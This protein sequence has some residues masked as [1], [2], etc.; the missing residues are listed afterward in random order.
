MI[1]ISKTKFIGLSVLFLQFIICSIIQLFGIQL[2]YER[3]SILAL[4]QTLL[5]IAVL[6]VSGLPIV[7]VPNM[8]G[9]FSLLFH[10]A[11]II[12]KGFNIKGTVPLPFENYAEISTIQIAFS[13]YLI[14]QT[15]YYI[16]L[17]VGF[18]SHEESIIA[19]KYKN[20]EE[21]ADTLV[22]GKVLLILGTIPR[23]YIDIVS[24]IGARNSGYAG[25]Y[26]LYIPG[27][28][29]AMAFFFDA[30]L[31]FVLFGCKKRSDV[32]FFAVLVYKC[33]M[34]TTGSRQDKVVFLLIW[35]YIFFF[36]INQ[37]TF[38]KILALVGACVVGFV[39]IS[40]VGAA[41][42][43]DSTGIRET[44]NVMQDGK[45]SNMLGGSLGE[46]GASFVTLE[47]AI[48][49]TPSQ[50][51]YGYGRSYLA[52]VLS[53]IPL[54]VKQIPVLAKTGYFLSQLPDDLTFAFG[55][56]YLGELYYNF[57]WVGI[58]GSYVVGS[59]NITL[60][61]SLMSKKNITRKCLDAI[62]ATAMILFVRGYFTDMAQKLAWTYFIVYI[63]R[64]CQQ[65]KRRKSCK[66]EWYNVECRYTDL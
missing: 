29:Q 21:D 33:L 51:A 45:L 63:V 32:V 24:L 26:S 46:F 54:L 12:K 42:G 9:V 41:R 8:F 61:N 53:I 30:G 22:Y 23:L 57:S 66:E 39:F 28:I 7:S 25:V 50:M 37:I 35:V 62:V 60:H 34:M 65:R 15:V 1:R 13:F 27:P 31:I 14:S 38:T 56:S 4:T 59:T 3:M 2:S 49:Y 11:Q 58:V 43:G 55:G 5:D 47:V 6:K 19:A 44:L 48:R 16:A 20:L 18:H 10:C 36:I 17:L 52:G 40:A 64:L